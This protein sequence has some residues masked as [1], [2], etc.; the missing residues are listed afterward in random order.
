MVLEKSPCVKNARAFLIL[1]KMRSIFANYFVCK[2]VLFATSQQKRKNKKKL[3]KTIDIPP[4]Q[5]YSNIRKKHRG[6]KK[7]KQ[8]GAFKATEF[9]KKQINVIYGKAKSGQLKVEKWYMTNLYNLADYY[10]YDDNR[11]VE[12]EEVFIKKILDA[13]FDGDLETAQKIIKERTD[14]TYES[15]SSKNKEK[16]NRELYI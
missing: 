9:T 2:K 5:W 15:L 4:N 13:I 11:S 10:G 14:S 16:C 7:M 1:Q 12:F 3:E 6:D 8:N